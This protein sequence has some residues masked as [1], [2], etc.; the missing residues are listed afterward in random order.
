MRLAD[1]VITIDPDIDVEAMVAK[2]HAAHPPV[3]ELEAGEVGRVG[4]RRSPVVGEHAH[5]AARTVVI[6]DDE[7]GDFRVEAFP[8]GN[9]VVEKAL[10]PFHD[11]GSPHRIVGGS[12]FRPVFLADD[13]GAVKGVIEATPA[14]IRRVQ[15]VPG[16]V[17]RHHELRPRDRRDLRIHIVRRDRERALLLEEIAR[18]REESPVS[19]RVGGLT[20][21]F[22][23]PCIEPFF[24]TGAH[25]EE[26]A[27]LGSEF[28]DH[29]P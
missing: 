7:V 15:G 19:G 18:L 2:E 24:V 22:L 27:I 10:G 20:L 28:L 8:Q 13:I 1:G 3:L 4:R 26:A 21:P 16:V 9:D 12:S 29:G 25:V 11:P 17:H 5:E 6:F 14:R 23:I